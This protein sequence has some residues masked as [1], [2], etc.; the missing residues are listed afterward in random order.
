MIIHVPL[1]VGWV[2]TM[3]YLCFV[4]FDHLVIDREPCSIHYSLAAVASSMGLAANVV[5]FGSSHHVA[6]MNNDN[7]CYHQV[8]IREC[9]SEDAVIAAMVP[10]TSLPLFVIINTRNPTSS[11]SVCRYYGRCA[12]LAYSCNM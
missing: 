1:T 5:I 12:N 9:Y 11:A 2:P 10:M 7:V 8:I 6:E 3:L 4:L